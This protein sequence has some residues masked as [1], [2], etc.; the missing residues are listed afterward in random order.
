MTFPLLLHAAVHVILTVHSS[1][2]YILFLVT[3]NTIEKQKLTN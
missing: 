2:G 1:L 3:R